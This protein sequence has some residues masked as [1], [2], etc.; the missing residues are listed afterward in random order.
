MRV[1][2]QRSSANTSNY[3]E[4]WTASL[5]NFNHAKPGSESLHNLT[6][7]QY[8]DYVGIGPGAHGRIQHG[9]QKIAVKRIASQKIG[10]YRSSLKVTAHRRK[11]R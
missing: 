9:N 4:R 8:G 7:W 5:R 1:F 2:R 10:G 11:H 3:G 6:Y